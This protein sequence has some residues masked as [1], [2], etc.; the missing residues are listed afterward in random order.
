VRPLLD[1]A[2]LGQDNDVVSVPHSG[3]VVG[4]G[5]G[6]AAAGGAV[7][8]GLDDLLAPRVDGAG[9]FV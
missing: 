1:H 3:E 5:D 4:D 7:E 6:G 8:R 2:A 9:G